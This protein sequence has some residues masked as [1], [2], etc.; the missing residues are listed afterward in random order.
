M[1]LGTCLPNL[2][3]SLY[4]SL[5]STLLQKSECASSFSKTRS[6]QYF[7]RFV[8]AV[9]F[10]YIT[11]AITKDEALALLKKNEPT[12]KAREAEVKEKGYPAYTTSVGWLGYTDEKVRRLTLSSLEQGFNHF[13]VSS[14]HPVVLLSSR[15]MVSSRSER[16]RKMIC[17]EV[18]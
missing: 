3:E 16:I 1:P 7:F 10:R 14:A 4:G 12:K 5:L 8:K 15:S 2:E 13:K 18:C 11:D 9:S 17:E 6:L